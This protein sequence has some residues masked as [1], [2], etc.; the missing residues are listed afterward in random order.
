VAQAGA[1][2]ISI[3]GGFIS[4]ININP[5]FSGTWPLLGLGTSVAAFAF[6]AS[7]IK[8]PIYKTLCNKQFT[9]AIKTMNNDESN[10]EKNAAMISQQLK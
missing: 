2:P 5:P 3:I 8:K 10:L 1:L 9:E 6:S 7:E 4:I